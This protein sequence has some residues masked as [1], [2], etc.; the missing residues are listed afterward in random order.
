LRNR[1]HGD[2]AGDGEAGRKC[3]YAET[4]SNST[5]ADVPAATMPSTHDDHP[6]SNPVSYRHS[7]TR[8]SP[9]SGVFFFLG[10]SY[11]RILF[12]ELI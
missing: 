4:Q 5:D 7:F 9:I 3:D 11:L 8:Q 12:E 2:E 10:F 6:L 1:V